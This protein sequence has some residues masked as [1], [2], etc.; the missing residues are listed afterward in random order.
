MGIG[1]ILGG[2]FG[3]G[4]KAATRA[5]RAA[6][7]QSAGQLGATTIWGTAGRSAYN[8]FSPHLESYAGSFLRGAAKPAI[9]AG[10]AFGVSSGLGEIAEQTDSSFIGAAASLGSFWAGTIGFRQALRAPIRGARAKWGYRKDALGGAARQLSRVFDK[11][12]FAPEKMI[13]GGMKGIGKTVGK[14]QL[15][16]RTV[17]T[18]SRIPFMLRPLHG[19][20]G[21]G[22]AVVGGVG[23]RFR[24]LGGAKNVPGI[25]G[26]M[27]GVRHPFL[28][29]LG[30][31]ATLGAVDSVTRRRAGR[32]GDTYYHPAPSGGINPRNYGGGMTMMNARG[33]VQY[34]MGSDD[35]SRRMT[36]GRAY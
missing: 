27:M 6:T 9:K 19:M 14:S 1:K 13:F 23:D 17:A 29:A 18:D 7:K 3:V 20:A 11:Y 21:I 24:M 31:G 34:R 2:A 35:M 12:M 22:R 33:G 32:S 5:G 8:R 26:R 36:R 16:I 10:M 4:R 30:A 25:M 28:G 15:G